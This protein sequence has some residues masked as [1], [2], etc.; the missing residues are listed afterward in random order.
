MASDEGSDAGRWVVAPDEAR[1]DIAIGRDTKLA[2]EVRQA[3][4]NLARAIEQRS[5][6]EGYF[7]CGKVE[8]D[9]CQ[10]NIMCSSVWEH[11]S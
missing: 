2:P 8:I 6:V 4:E 5:E 1:I 7:F 9:E 3:L 10:V 11:P